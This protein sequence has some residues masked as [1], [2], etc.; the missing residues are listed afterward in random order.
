MA[1]RKS[2]RDKAIVAL[3]M[4]KSVQESANYAGIGKRTLDRWLSEEDFRLQL[5]KSQQAVF[6]RHVA[7]LAELTGMGIKRLSQILRDDDARPGDWMRACEIVM[8][9]T[10][11]SESARVRAALQELQSDFLER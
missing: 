7:A 6:E 2:Q 5:E 8:R 11:Q 10:R 9:E 3:L 4:G 1:R